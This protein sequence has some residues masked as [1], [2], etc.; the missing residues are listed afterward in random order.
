MEDTVDIAGL[1]KVE[2][3]YRLWNNATPAIFSVMKAIPPQFPR[4]AATK[5][6]TGYIDYFDGRPIKMSFRKDRIDP[7]CY[8]REFGE[9]EVARI[10]AELRAESIK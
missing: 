9:G 8:D 4:E 1:D 6:V 10:V 2:L 3:L 7:W 5:A